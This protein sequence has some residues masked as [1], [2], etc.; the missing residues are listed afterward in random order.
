MDSSQVSN[1]NATRAA[2]EGCL[3]V[4]DSYRV[5]KDNADSTINALKKHN[6]SLE[7]QIDIHEKK[8]VQEE[9]SIEEKNIIIKKA[10]K[11]AKLKKIGN[12]ILFSTFAVGSA[13]LMVLYLT[14]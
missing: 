2:L 6:K 5:V 12:S 4:V 7:N 8:D 14:K 1:S 11:K 10:E 3:D 9:A 13:V